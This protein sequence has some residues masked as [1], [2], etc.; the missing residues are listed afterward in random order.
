M[1]VVAQKARSTAPVH[2]KRFKIMRNQ[3]LA[4][5]RGVSYEY[6]VQMGK[7]LFHSSGGGGCATPTP[8]PPTVTEY[9]LFRIVSMRFPLGWGDPNYEKNWI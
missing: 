5:R 9:V 6:G 3:Q 7:N 4:E 8:P 2:A 1:R